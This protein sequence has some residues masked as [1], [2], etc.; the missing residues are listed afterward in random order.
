MRA[1]AS[2]PGVLALSSSGCPGSVLILPQVSRAEKVKTARNK[3]YAHR[4]SECPAHTLRRGL[5]ARGG[6]FG[7]AA[8]VTTGSEIRS[9]RERR[10][11]DAIAH[12]SHEDR[13]QTRAEHRI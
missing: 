12:P 9:C 6:Q 13:P 2:E 8:A 11:S 4:D 5:H 3:Q 10:G 1:R 7:C